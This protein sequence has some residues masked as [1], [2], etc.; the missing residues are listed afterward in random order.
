MQRSIASSCWRLT[1]EAFMHQSKPT[2]ELRACLNR[3][4][5]AQIAPWDADMKD[6]M[7][8]H[9]VCHTPVAGLRVSHLAK[10]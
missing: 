9:K 3:S 5:R 1:L 6:H 4:C 7:T 8:Y 2:K 10:R